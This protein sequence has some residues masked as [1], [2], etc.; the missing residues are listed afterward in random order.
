M[1]DDV[2]EKSKLPENLLMNIV[3]FP[4]EGAL[5]Y[6]LVSF[7]LTMLSKRNPEAS[8]AI[9]RAVESGA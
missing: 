8:A 3:G 5:S 2:N 4:G 9:P 6:R 1:E 7:L